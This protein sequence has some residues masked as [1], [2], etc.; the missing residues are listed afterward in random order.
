[1]Q[2]EDGITGTSSDSRSATELEKRE[3]IGQENQL[4]DKIIN[5]DGSMKDMIIQLANIVKQRIDL[6][7][8][9]FAVSEIS[10]YI[11]RQLRQLDCPIASHVYEY[12]PDEYKNPSYSK[13]GKVG[14]TVQMLAEGHV[15]SG[16]QLEQL[17]NP[18]MEAAYE[19]A[20][21]AKD[22]LDHAISQLNKQKSQMEFVAYK[23]KYKLGGYNWR[24]PISENDFDEPVPDSIEWFVDRNVEFFK[25]IG[26]AFHSIAEKYSRAP[27]REQEELEEDYHVLETFYQ[28]LKPLDDSKHTGDILH[29][30]ER[31]Y[32][33]AG[34]SKHA[35]GNSDKFD[36]KICIKCSDI[37]TLR[38]DPEYELMIYDPTSP[39]KLRCRKCNGT[40]PDDRFMSREEVGDRTEYLMRVAG[41]VIRY[42]PL[43]GNLLTRW[44]D[45]HIQPK[46]D[47]RK[48][49]L[50]AF[51]EDASISG[52]SWKVAKE[53]S[54]D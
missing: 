18:E 46:E 19:Q 14:K 47:S 26:N 35:A 8:C 41:N 53:V 40:I 43:L 3:L 48:D 52:A 39:T 30:F 25:K 15:P 17:S 23:K 29:Q 54:L 45:N 28:V 36:T 7:D 42:L 21:K 9:D 5:H 24:R 1:M 4:I 22:E 50:A 13:W 16:Y 49:V 44:S 27:P 11:T 33:A 10:T 38:A 20:N 32:I 2:A 34:Q 51:F 31:Q 37:D 12:L 6:L